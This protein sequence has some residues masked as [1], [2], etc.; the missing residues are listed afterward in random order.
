MELRKILLPTATTLLPPS[1]RQRLYSELWQKTQIDVAV[2]ESEDA[3]AIKT[4]PLPY[5]EL[6]FKV[7]NRLS[8]PLQVYGASVEIWLGKPVVVFYSLMSELLHPDETRETLRAYT[9]LNNFQ[10]DLLNPPAKNSP[11]PNVKIN[12][13]VSCRSLLGHVEKSIQKTWIAPKILP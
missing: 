6:Q 3:L 7:T 5:L 10:A 4:H 11:P 8:V 13:T 12:L 1:L 9:F 2:R